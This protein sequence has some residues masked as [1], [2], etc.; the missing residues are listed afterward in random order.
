MMWLTQERIS[1]IFILSLEY[2]YSD[3][4]SHIK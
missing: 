2:E 1:K 4:Y 3:K